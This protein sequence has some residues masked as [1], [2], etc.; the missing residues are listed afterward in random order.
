VSLTVGITQTATLPP[1]DLPTQELLEA[2]VTSHL[3]TPT[4]ASRCQRSSR[5]R[6]TCSAAPRQGF[7]LAG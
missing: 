2:T 6:S 1:A 5:T 7:W 3:R 4:R